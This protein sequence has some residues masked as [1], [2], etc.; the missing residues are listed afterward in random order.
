VLRCTRP[1]PLDSRRQGRPLC[2]TSIHEPRPSE[3]PSQLERPNEL[4][5]HQRPRLLHLNIRRISPT[6]DRRSFSKY[7]RRFIPTKA[8]ERA[9]LA[10]RQASR[11]KPSDQPRAGDV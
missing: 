8:L 1:Q 9:I 6:I 7:Q 4:V 5:L 11:S 2:P 10:A 3:P